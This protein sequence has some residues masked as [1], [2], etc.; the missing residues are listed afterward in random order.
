[1][2]KPQSGQ[3]MVEYVVVLMFGVMLL[4]IGPGGDIL[5]DLLAVFHDNYQGYSYAT[6]LSDLPQYDSLG[7]YILE[8][9]EEE[10]DAVG[11]KLGEL[12]N[13]VPSSPTFTMPSGIP[14]SVNDLTSGLSFF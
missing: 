14:P 5:L 12:Y 9:N 8:T 3:G 13:S 4:T 11:R 7:E 1:M 10:V 6:S 2:I